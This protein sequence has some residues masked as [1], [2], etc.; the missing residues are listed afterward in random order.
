MATCYLR[1]HKKINIEASFVLNC[2]E[3]GLFTRIHIFIHVIKSFAKSLYYQ[4]KLYSRNSSSNDWR[5]NRV[6]A[7]IFQSRQMVFRCICLDFACCWVTDGRHSRI[8][9]VLRPNNLNFVSMKD[10]NFCEL[11]TSVFLPS[12]STVLVPVLCQLTFFLFFRF[13]EPFENDFQINFKNI[14]TLSSPTN[15]SRKMLHVT[16]NF[17]E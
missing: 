15:F 9:G 11:F 1:E 10:K 12:F 2:Q 8:F 6:L 7:E 5:Y 14:K 16:T 3:W 17:Q 13:E 4:Q